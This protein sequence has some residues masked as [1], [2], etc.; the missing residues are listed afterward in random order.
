MRG[1]ADRS[2]TS[3]PYN[4]FKQYPGMQLRGHFTTKTKSLE[5]LKITLGGKGVLMKISNSEQG[6]LMSIV[7][8]YK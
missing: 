4:S 5:H 3:K 6:D 2:Q 1:L 8:G 7:K